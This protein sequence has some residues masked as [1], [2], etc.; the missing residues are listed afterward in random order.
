MKGIILAGGS[1]TRLYPLTRGVSKQLL[2]IYDKPMIYYP[3]STLMLAGIRDILIITTPE[4]NDSFKRLLGDGSDF[5]IRLQYAVQPS[6]DGLAQ[7]F[8]IGEEFIDDSNVCLVLGDNIFYGQSFSKTLKSAA[9]RTFG[10]TVFGYQVKDP[11]RFGV[12]EFDADMK[13]ISIEEKPAKPKSNYAVTGLYFY[14]NKVVELAKLVKPS[15]RG[16]LEITTLNEMYLKAGEL[17][18]ELLGRGFAWLD[19]G[20]HESLHEASSFVQTIEHVQGLKVACLEE[21]AYRN[22]WLTHEQLHELAKPMLK[23]DYGQYLAKLL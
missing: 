19:T 3:L 7:A 21:I 10:A 13:A 16:E 14:D 6:P 17:N 15:H 8:I 5:G 2:P 1:G 22:G 23:N 9:S 4:D 20:T 12:V 18:V 11:E